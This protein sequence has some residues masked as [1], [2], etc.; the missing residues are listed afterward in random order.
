VI[1]AMMAFF[2]PS[3]GLISFFYQ[4]FLETALFPAKDKNQEIRRS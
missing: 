3:A 1:P 4:D 2:M